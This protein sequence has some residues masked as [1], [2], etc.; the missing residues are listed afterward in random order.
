MAAED[1][2]QTKGEGTRETRD[3]PH[4]C[5]SCLQ[6]NGLGVQFC[7]RCGAALPETPADAA[8]SAVDS[9]YIGKLIENRYRVESVIGRGGMGCVY[10][11]EQVHLKKPLALKML[12]ENLLSRRSQV[13]K[14][15]REARA[16]SRLESP[17]T[18]RLYD[19]G[20]YGEIFYLV[21]ELIEG[22]ELD[23]I[24]D[25]E[26][27][28]APERAVRLLAQVCE[29]LT[30]AHSAGV[31]HRDLKPENIMVVAGADGEMAKVL[32]FGLAKVHDAE[33]LET[34]QSGR[35][36]FGTP[37]Y[38]AP[39][40]IRALAVDARTDV[41][42]VG[43]M[44]FRLLTGT[45]A[46]NADT[47]F[48]I[49]KRHLTDPVPSMRVR[50]PARPIS[51]SLDQV[52]MRCLAKEPADRYATTA[53]LREAL[54]AAIAQPVEGPDAPPSAVSFVD[55]PAG[56]ITHVASF[57]R[58]LERRRI[59]YAAAL[60]VVVVSALAI[61]W[62][63]VR[64]VGTTVAD[65][66]E[67]EPN[68]QVESAD[69]LAP[70]ATVRGTLG[71][72]VS[73]TAGDLDIYAIEAPQD[74]QLGVTLT[75]LPGIDVVLEL[76][77]AEGRVL[78]SFDRAGTGDGETLHHLPVKEGLVFVGVRESLRPGAM[79]RESLSDAYE[80][81]A[82]FAPTPETP[83]ELEVDDTPALATRIDPDIA[84]AGWLD[85]RG[86][87]DVYRL[88]GGE[89]GSTRW[90]VSFEA[91]VGLRLRVELAN[92]REELLFEA[93]TQAA[94]PS[95][96]L[97]FVTRADST[98]MRYLS[99]AAGRGSATAGA[100]TVTVRRRPEARS[101][102]AEP[103]EDADHATPLVL[104]EQVEGTFERSDHD[105]YRLELPG[106]PPRSV[107]LTVE[108]DGRVGPVVARLDGAGQ[109][110]QIPQ[111]ADGARRSTRDVYDVEVEGPT[112][113]VRLSLPGGRKGEGPY[114]LRVEPAP[115][116]AAKAP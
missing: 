82:T 33:D 80:L 22:R 105:T 14:F 39:E 116:V 73:A 16:I 57:E 64:T 104:G 53:D 107:R 88:D 5:P 6:S 94:T 34:I 78:Q 58:R 68:N 75:G 100:Y 72:R 38:M 115:V 15:L 19:F 103:N 9:H 65:G 44:A 114:L 92:G 62:T 99:V 93:M 56:P 37:Y 86:D 3:L 12:H 87:V 13:S 76:M 40:Q 97:E 60:S 20:R 81:G 45:Y 59:L 69:R 77:D 46:F 10:R 66:A 108:R 67:H 85:G 2:K 18:V 61:V 24:L 74:G 26:G 29:S 111:A 101:R 25:E 98:P 11:V 51:R 17:H 7:T 21:M 106:S 30:E 1:G 31:I 50:S 47:T 43:A 71:Q 42:A 89:L 8:E 113:V 96:T 36:M 41:Y 102:E 90:T 112:L 52:V 109:W 4:V 83:T 28:L 79:P 84:V 91:A 48:D 32:D 63:F 27:P 110:V 95:E 49:L 55:A 70:G 23:L 54:L 35:G